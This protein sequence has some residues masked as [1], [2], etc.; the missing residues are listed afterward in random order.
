MTR[1]IRFSPSAALRPAEAIPRLAA[2]ADTLNDSE[3][4]PHVRLSECLVCFNCIEDCPE[5]ALRFAF[6]PP[7][8]APA[9][10]LAAEV[11]EVSGVT[12]VPPGNVTFLTD[13]E[14]L[15]GI[16]AEFE[17]RRLT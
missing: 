11:S 15:A 8:Q 16:K 7:R 12:P 10:L 14:T 6:L 13:P 3:P 2:L 1:R 17:S 5:N 9:S 4:E